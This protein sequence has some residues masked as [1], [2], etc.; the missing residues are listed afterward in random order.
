V[1]T[2][3]LRERER[4]R[5]NEKIRG[6]LDFVSHIFLFF[7]TILGVSASH[8]LS[9]RHVVVGNGSGVE[10]VGMSG[11]ATHT[12]HTSFVYPDKGKDGIR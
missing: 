6:C 4:E 7:Q 1:S 5:E 8:L 11:V 3:T 12:P 10:L 2:V 9:L